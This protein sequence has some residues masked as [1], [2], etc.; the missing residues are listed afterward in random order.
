[1][2]SVLFCVALLAV[3]T[4]ASAQ[5]IYRTVT[6]SGKTIYSD[7]PVQNGSS[8]VQTKQINGLGAGGDDSD[9][10]AQGDKSCQADIKQYCT[11][12]GGGKSPV[13]CL[14][15]HQQDISDACYDALKKRMSAHQDDRDD[16]G[17]ARGGP[18]GG[19]PQ[20]GP[21]GG[22]PPG[23]PPG[24][25]ACKQ[26]AQRFCN[27]TQPGGGRIINCLMDHQND[28]SDTCYDALSKM[29]KSGRQ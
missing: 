5:S 29:V 27:G 12:S 11:H 8:G 6:S 28:I 16:Q 2:R 17:E 26:D 23:P 18:P 4:T 25:Q 3:A 22:R 19:E 7:T 21:G 14:L 10:S 1:M 9:P 24:A 15:D 20:G 13:D